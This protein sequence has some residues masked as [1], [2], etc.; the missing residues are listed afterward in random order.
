VSREN[1]RSARIGL[2]STAGLAAGYSLIVGLSSRSWAHLLSQWRADLWFIVLVALGFG[3]Q[4]GLYSHLRRLVRGDG[5][6]VVVASAG[7]ATSTTAM[8]ACCLHHLADAVPFI[9]LSAAATVLIQYKVYVVALSLAANA[10][11]ILL[12]L[13]ALRHARRAAAAC[14]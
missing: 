6:A 13:R 10:A 1:R 4:M 14:P 11:G 5:T 2:L 3:T 8:A 9:G 12:M 7:T